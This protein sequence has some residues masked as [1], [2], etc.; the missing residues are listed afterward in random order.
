[1]YKDRLAKWGFRKNIHEQDVAQ[2]LNEKGRRDALG[3]WPKFTKEGREIPTKRVMAYMRRKKLSET[4]L[5]RHL[6]SA[7]APSQIICRSASPISIKPPQLDRSIEEIAFNV[8]RQL[9][10]WRESHDMSTKGS[11]GWEGYQ[12]VTPSTWQLKD[13]IFYG[14]RCMEQSE[15]R[16]GG[17]LLRKAFLNAEQSIRHLDPITPV[18][19]LQLFHCLRLQKVAEM[20]VDHLY[21]LSSHFHPQHLV[22]QLLHSLKCLINCNNVHEWGSALETFLSKAIPG[23]DETFGPRGHGMDNLYL[24]SDWSRGKCEQQLSQ[25]IVTIHNE[26]PRDHDKCY[27]A[28]TY[29]FFFM[30]NTFGWQHSGT[31]EAAL[32]MVTHAEA[33]LKQS[34]SSEADREIRRQ[35][36]FSLEKLAYCHKGYCTAGSGHMNM[37]HVLARQMLRSAIEHGIVADGL[38]SPDV[39]RML[40]RL[41]RWHQEAENL[42]CAE[43]VKHQLR[44]AYALERQQA[45]L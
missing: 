32:L 18:R 25:T 19:L 2:I 5:L 20:L 31:L 12:S 35:L 43:E 7:T 29:L 26:H 41:S 23:I 30:H 13:W 27:D 8:I 44:Q 34:R 9:R 21:C 3:K 17:M 15:C 16:R 4:D 14:Q 1:M 42:I 33:R 36:S 11:L 39:I 6:G 38:Q 22:T 40:E 10:A 37:R 28:A 45:G 24:K